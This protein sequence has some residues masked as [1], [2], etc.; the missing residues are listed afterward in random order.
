MSLVEADEV[1]QPRSF[2]SIGR[3]RMPRPAAS[4]ASPAPLMPPPM[5]ARSKSAMLAPAARHFSGAVRVAAWRALA[6]ALKR[7]GMSRPAKRCDDFRRGV[8][9][10]A[11]RMD[12]RD[13]YV[14]VT[15]GAGALGGAV[16]GALLEA[17]AV[18]HVP[19][20]TQDE[21]QRFSYRGHAGVKVVA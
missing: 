12:F 1:A 19:C 10:G 9:R 16:V 3:T 15:G 2:C 17:G 14:V 13:R 8:G 4:R 5:I 18:C 11:D 20:R 6:P 7:L 21:A